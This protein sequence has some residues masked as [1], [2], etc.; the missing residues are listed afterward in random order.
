MELKERKMMFK[1]AANVL[2]G[3]E[4]QVMNILYNHNLN[5][6]LHNK[7]I[8][9]EL[10]ESGILKFKLSTSDFDINLS[11]INYTIVEISNNDDLK[12]TKLLCNHDISIYMMM[13]CD[14]HD[15]IFTICD[16][17]NYQINNCHNVH[18]LI[19][20]KGEF[21]I[22]VYNSR[23]IVINIDINLSTNYSMTSIE[24]KIKI[25]YMNAHCEENISEFQSNIEIIDH[26]KS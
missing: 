22:N 13:I 7:K 6:L 26:H 12:K 5:R 15:D 10:N 18:L 3:V 8:L 17:N 20:P 4:K 21:S 14:A 2:N 11:E 16:V 25:Y 24:S 19:K 1:R 23:D 9:D